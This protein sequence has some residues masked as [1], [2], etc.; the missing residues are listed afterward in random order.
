[1]SAICW[2]ATVF[3]AFFVSIVRDP[4]EIGRD[5]TLCVR[6]ENAEEEGEGEELK[7]TD[8]STR[9]R[10]LRGRRDSREPR[11]SKGSERKRKNPEEES[12]G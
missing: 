3:I 2:K 1:M 10:R 12:K 8:E 9:A 7:G 5:E 6:S 11:K 4:V